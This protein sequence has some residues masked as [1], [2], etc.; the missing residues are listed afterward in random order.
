M[1]NFITSLSVLFLL[2]IG[3][4]TTAQQNV[5]QSKLDLVFKAF[6]T[7][8]YAILKPLVDANVLIDPKIPVGMND[9][10]L[11]QVIA[12]VP[13]PESYK[14]LKSEKVDGGQRFT[15]E[16]IY[17]DRKRLQYFTFNAEGKIVHLDIL[18]D[19]KTVE[20]SFGTN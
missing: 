13:T 1:K 10:V 12:Q 9:A 17:K 14:I 7:K 18:S 2:M 5:Y 15:T 16:Y 6:N 11:P 19:A 8:D 20:A 4:V 3:T